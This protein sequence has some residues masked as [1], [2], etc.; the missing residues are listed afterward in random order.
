MWWPTSANA[1]QA[2]PADLT[3]GLVGLDGDFLRPQTANGTVLS[4]GGELHIKFFQT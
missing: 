1:G 2:G 4:G 3:V